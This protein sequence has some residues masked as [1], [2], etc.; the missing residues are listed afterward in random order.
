MTFVSITVDDTNF[1]RFIGDTLKRQLPFA[2]ANALNATAN[3]MQQ[4]VRN[5][6]VG[7]RGF[8]IRSDNSRR[9][10]QN[11]IR[12]NP[13]EDF[14]RKTNL[15]ARIRIQNKGRS[16]LLGLIDQG[17]QRSSRFSLGPAT[18]GDDLPIP[19]RATPTA[20]VSRS[21]YPGKLGLQSRGGKALKGAKRTFVVR[22][23]AGDTLLLQ[24]RGKNRIRTLF[25]LER[26]ADVRPRQFFAPAAER[27]AL[28]RFDGNLERAL[29]R[30]LRT[31]R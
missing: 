28:T 11:Q 5:A 12:R 25:V 14:A 19:V 2:T 8:V 17:G 13:G 6:V 31:A 1:R 3:D 18:A 10:L 16:S 15:V 9:F 26:K 30:A 23:K 22:T 20:T 4:A 7:S 24:R 29:D 27:A 21:L